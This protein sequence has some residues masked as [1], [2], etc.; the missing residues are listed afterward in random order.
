MNAKIHRVSKGKKVNKFW[1]KIFD[2]HQVEFENYL[3]FRE[4]EEYNNK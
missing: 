3:C 4:K 1:K 2:Q